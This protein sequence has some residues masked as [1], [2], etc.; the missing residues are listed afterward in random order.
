[1][2]VP[3]DRDTALLLYVGI[4]TDT[5]SFRYSNTTAVTHRIVSRLLK[6][7]FEIPKIYKYI[8]ENIPFNDMLLLSRILPKIKQ[9]FQGKLVW[10]QIEK[11][12]LR[13]QERTTFDLSE[14]V[15]SFERAIADAEV[16]VLFKEN[17]KTA[18]EIRVNFRS[19]G[20]VDVNDIARTF[21]GGGHRT[22]SGCTIKATL[23]E[24]KKKV[25]KRIERELKHES[26]P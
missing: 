15:L 19:H 14:H 16:A 7:K 17:L 2:G 8:Y 6:Y 11:T 12:I 3:I 21:G 1:M 5:G 25:F 18:G 10:C 23:E 4:M 26:N 13:N 22:A 9:K 20:T 24:A